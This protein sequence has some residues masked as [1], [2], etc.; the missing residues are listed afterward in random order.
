MNIRKAVITAAGRNQRTL[1][2]QVLVD[3]DG[4]ERAVLAILVEE[5]RSAGIEEIAIVVAPG[6]EIPYSKVIAGSAARP[7]FI[8]QEEPLGYGNAVQ[9]AAEFVG[10]EPFLLLLGD[11]LYV[12][13]GEKSCARH[14]VEVA[15]LESCSVSTV[16]ATRESLLP[17]FGVVGGKRVAGSKD[18]YVVETVIE[19]PTPTEAE[20][21][22]LVPG[23]RAGYYLGFFGMHV[24]TPTVMEILARQIPTSRNDTPPTLSDALNSLASQ[25]KYLALEQEARR[26]DVGVRY[27]LLIAQLALAF[28]GHDREE[29][30]T[31]ILELLAQ[32]ELAHH[33]RG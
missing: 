20:L 30:L 5:A 14:L 12:S 31:R 32:R 19:K 17:F 33:R 29:V 6:D 25:E 11:H 4:N 13:S 8:V 2:M 28:S 26:Y 9:C 15:Q 1:P 21:R 22:L 3:R 18:L 27:G 10:K 24:L 23:F 7:C 16:Q